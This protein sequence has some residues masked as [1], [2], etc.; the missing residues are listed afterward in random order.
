MDNLDNARHDHQKN[1]SD[2]VNL[3]K[4]MFAQDKWGDQE[5]KKALIDLVNKDE[6]LVAEVARLLKAR[7]E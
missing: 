7:H 5:Y 2:I 6:K 1:K 3:V 4:Q